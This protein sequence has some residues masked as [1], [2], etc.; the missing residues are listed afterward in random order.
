MNPHARSAEVAVGVKKRRTLPVS[1]TV[2][3]PI[4]S[5]ILAGDRENP[6]NAAGLVLSAYGSGGSRRSPRNQSVA[7]FAARWFQKH[8][9]A[10]W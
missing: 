1:A 10:R 8:L 4:G 2:R 7:R 9:W 6:A 5:A 3:I